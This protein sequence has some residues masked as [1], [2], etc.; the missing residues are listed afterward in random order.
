MKLNIKI[1]LIIICSF[2]A[3]SLFFVLFNKSKKEILVPDVVVSEVIVSVG[4]S[5]EKKDK[6]V[7][8]SPKANETI[9]S[10]LKVTGKA[11]GGWYFEASFPVYL[12]DWDGKIIG[13]GIAKAQGKWMTD[14][15]V[16]FIATINFVNSTSTYS[17]KA[18]LVLKKDNPSGLPANDDALEIPVIL[19]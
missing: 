1:I 2:L 13:T 17:K 12:T 8:D 4:N 5:E 15:F 11:R 9:S 3:I 7:L 16:P 14:N 18:T 10:P 6:I 19:Q